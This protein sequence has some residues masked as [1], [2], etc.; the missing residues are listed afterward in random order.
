MPGLIKN[1][2]RVVYPL[3]R[4]IQVKGLP[5]KQ[6]NKDCRDRYGNHDDSTQQ[7]FEL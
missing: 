7:R 6:S 5:Q 3:H 1:A 4:L 2:I